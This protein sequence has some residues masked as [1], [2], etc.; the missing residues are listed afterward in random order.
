MPQ[1]KVRFE[2]FTARKLKNM[3]LDIREDLKDE[4]MSVRNAI[5]QEKDLNCIKRSLG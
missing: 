4:I 1:K 3:Q 5:T 2:Q